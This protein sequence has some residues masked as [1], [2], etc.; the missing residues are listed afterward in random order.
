MIVISCYQY[1]KIYI[2]AI[3]ISIYEKNKSNKRE[4]SDN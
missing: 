3:M 2:N 4:I 1:G